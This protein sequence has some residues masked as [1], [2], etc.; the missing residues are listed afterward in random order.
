MDNFLRAE[1]RI[2]NTSGP[3]ICKVQY[4]DTDYLLYLHSAVATVSHYALD[5][6]RSKVYFETGIH[7]TGV[8]FKILLL[9]FFPFFNFT[10]IL[11]C[12]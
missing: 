7:S 9:F 1:Y 5:E 11:P 8:A 2:R 4:R 12:F 10:L 3:E 6:N